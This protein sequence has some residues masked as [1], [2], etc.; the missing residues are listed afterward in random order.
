MTVIFGV[1]GRDGR[2]LA[3]ALLARAVGLLWGWTQ[4]PELERSLRGKPCFAD[5]PD[6]WLSL[7]HSG[8]YALCAL[9]EDGPV[10]VDIEV[11]RPHRP[12]LPA[13]A[14][15]EAERKE[16][17]GSWEDFAR[18]WTRKE[19]WCKQSDR[20]LY[21]PRLAAVPANCTCQSYQ[22]SDWRAA[23]CCCG[24]PPEAIRWLDLPALEA[25]SGH[26]GKP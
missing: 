22:G 24:Q 19:S 26:A 9:S 5:R 1:Q 7:S 11:V 6:R 12:G 4:P 13:Y 18:L 15:T 16:F 25:A 23:V 21:P 3:H 20:P 8:G 2:Q 17:D 14:L 10:G